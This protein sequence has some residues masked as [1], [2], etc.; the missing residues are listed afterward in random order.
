VDEVDK[1]GDYNSQRVDPNS[2][3]ATIEENDVI[4]LT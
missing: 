3:G 4:N 2:F 1:L